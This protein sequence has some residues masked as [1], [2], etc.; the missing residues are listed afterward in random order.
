M[1]ESLAR[2]TAWAKQHPYIAGLLVIAVVFLAYLTIKNRGSGGGETIQSDQG[3]GDQS[4]DLGSGSDNAPLGSDSL[5]N[6]GG[7][8]V[9]VP[10]AV[11]NNGG[12][13]LS[14]EGA[15]DHYGMSTPP[16]YSI[17]QG[18]Y[19][20]A[21]GV[22]VSSTSM[23]TLHYDQ[24]VPPIA[25]APVSP[26]AQAVAKNPTLATAAK[27]Q[28]KP[29]P[30]SPIAKVIAKSPALATAA[31]PMPATPAQKAGLPRL[32]SGTSNGVIYLM[33]FITGY[34]NTKPTAKGTT[35]G[36]TKPTKK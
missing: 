28:P 9:E 35:G 7:S 8:P 26:I 2:L 29:A 10:A 24:V 30:V 22:P 19:A 32:F 14:G 31:K 16:A 12:G 5:S 27:P 34:T 11:E 20:M 23:D 1:K 6:L 18:S 21:Q 17:D 33:G 13:G 25:I 3:T 15:S 36:G 4:S